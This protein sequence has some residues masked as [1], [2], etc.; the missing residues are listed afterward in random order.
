MSLARAWLA[1]SFVVALIGFGRVVTAFGSP[2]VVEGPRPGP[3][4]ESQLRL[5][6]DLVVQQTLTLPP[7]TAPEVALRVWIQPMPGEDK[8]LRVRGKVGAREHGWQDVALPRGKTT[9][10][11]VQLPWWTLPS[12]AQSMTVDLEGSGL[13]LLT[14]AVDRVAGGTLVINDVPHAPSD[15]V[16]Q[17]V[18]GDRGMDRHFP[19]SRFAEGKPGL[20]GLP[21]SFLMLGFAYVLFV[22][23][24]LPSAAWLIQRTREWTDDVYTSLESSSDRPSPP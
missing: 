24:L 20:L 5:G 11:S 14:T 19:F 13:V 6:R 16:L 23:V 18:S 3:L 4:G 21:H 9:V 7:L 10:H 8:F 15:L 12:E 22:I 2:W 1:V 17:I